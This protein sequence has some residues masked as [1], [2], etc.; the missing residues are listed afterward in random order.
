[1]TLR[2]LPRHRAG[3]HGPRGF[4]LVTGLIMLLLISLIGLAASR[5]IRQES[6]MANNTRERDLAFQAA[7]AAL[8]DG[9][10]KLQSVYHVNVLAN[11]FSLAGLIN[12]S[13]A[14][15]EDKIKPTMAK[16]WSDAAPSGYGW[17]DG[18][19]AVDTS[20]SIATGQTLTG[21]DQQARYVVE[22]LG[23]ES[24][25]VISPPCS[26][27]AYRYRFTALA[28]GASTATRKIADTRVMLQS[29]VMLCPA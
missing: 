27:T 6:V 18:N 24:P 13:T 29:E 7:E 2:N 11:D 8:A 26:M 17:F 28:V 19:G 21:V 4:A 25:P 1:M 9:E 20:K 22:F 12:R 5:G 16:Y 23:T 3:K 15:T 14:S 10:S